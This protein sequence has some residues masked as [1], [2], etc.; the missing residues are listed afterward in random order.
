MRSRGGTIRLRTDFA[1]RIIRSVASHVL[2]ATAFGTKLTCF[3][4]SWETIGSVPNCRAT[5]RIVR[6]QRS[7]ATVSAQKVRVKIPDSESYSD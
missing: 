5:V 4:A 7:P 6:T 3:V 1:R 2:V